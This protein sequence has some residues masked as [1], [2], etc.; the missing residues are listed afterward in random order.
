MKSMQSLET[1]I[2]SQNQIIK[3]PELGS[4]DLK[5]LLIPNNCLKTLPFFLISRCLKLEEVDLMH[6]R[7]WDKSSSDLF[8]S[9]L[10]LNLKL[11]RKLD[12]YPQSDPE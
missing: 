2:L 7:L 10:I 5:V 12:F 11:L 6:N 3:I 1:L 4:L 8:L 9:K